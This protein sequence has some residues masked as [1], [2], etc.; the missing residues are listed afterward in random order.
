MTNGGTIVYLSHSGG[1]GMQ[2]TT[3]T[4]NNYAINC[5][6]GSTNHF[7]LYNNG[8]I[9]VAGPITVG[10]TGNGGPRLFANTQDGASYTT[11]QGGLASWYGIGFK[12][13]LDDVT[14]HVWNTRTGDYSCTGTAR[15]SSFV[16]NLTGN[17]TGSSGSCTGTANYANSAGSASSAN[18]ANS[19][20]SAG[21]CTG[22][23][24][25]ANS[26]GSTNYANSA[27]S[28]GSAG[29]LT[30]SPGITIS[31][32]YVNSGGGSIVIA[33]PGVGA[34]HMSTNLA[35]VLNAQGYG[36]VTHTIFRSVGS[37]LNVG[38]YTEIGSIDLGGV[39]HSTSDD[40]LKGNEIFITDALST[41]SK[42]RPQIYDKYFHLNYDPNTDTSIRESGLIAQE[43]Y[44]D[45]PELRHL[46]T[47]PSDASSNITDYIAS[48]VDPRNDPNYS[49]TWGTKT[50][51]FNYTGLIP[52]TI[53]GIKELVAENTLLKAQIMDIQSRLNAANL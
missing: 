41:L 23:A 37:Y 13:D 24:N 38:S 49:T 52:W 10:L 43:V 16:G 12:C 40:R 6:N 30:G 35:F 9:V 14:R 31:S 21:S 53:Q 26:A 3:N 33:P 44:Y 17:C 27:G 8:A 18:Y 34:H 39:L 45:A 51:L 7:T 29:G 15:A 28:A 50:A 47:I 5:Y 46:V 25:Y 42:L 2:I 36:G 19:A 32:L 11:Y 22:T 4:T 48:S 20:G 1:Y